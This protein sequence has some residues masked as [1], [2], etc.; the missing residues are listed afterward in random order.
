MR[1]PLDTHT[2]LWSA[3]NSKR[4]SVKTIKLLQ[5]D[6]NELFFSVVSF[7]EISIK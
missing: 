5:D 6:E 7:W 1:F 3:G 2:M 4:L